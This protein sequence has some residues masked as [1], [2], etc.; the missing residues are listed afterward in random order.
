M[1]IDEKP[2]KEEAKAAFGMSF[3]GLKTKKSDPQ[4][5]PL[6]SPPKETKDTFEKAPVILGNENEPAKADSV[7]GSL[8]PGSP[9]E[10][11]EEIEA[12]KELKEEEGPDDLEMDDEEFLQKRM[13]LELERMKELTKK[14]TAVFN[15]NEKKLILTDN[16]RS[17]SSSNLSK[18]SKDTQKPE[19][20]EGSLE[21]KEENDGNN[22]EPNENGGSFFEVINET[23]IQDY[24][25]Q[26][27]DDSLGCLLTGGHFQALYLLKFAELVLNVLIF[28]VTF[29]FT[30]S[31]RLI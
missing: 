29:S 12:P 31:F 21:E 1:R 20:K 14:M 6:S 8:H 26:K 22:Q 4:T 23:D 3:K 2:K 17:N 27:I 24:I 7:S 30:N 28:F 11:Q 10:Q 25:H 19:N 9:L 13:L 18:I 5:P 15:K 16:F